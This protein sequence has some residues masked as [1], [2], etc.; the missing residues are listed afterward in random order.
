MAEATPGAPRTCLVYYACLLLT[1]LWCFDFWG[2][3]DPGGTAP[4]RVTQFLETAYNSAELIFKCKPTNPGLTSPPPPLLGSHI[5]GHYPL[6][7]ITPWPR[8]RQP[9]TASVPRVCW[10][11]SNQPILNLFTL[12]VPFLMQKPQQRLLSQFPLCLLTANVI[13]LILSVPH[14][15]LLRL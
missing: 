6:A 5:L 3:V 9:E 4:P 14:P 8:T 12:P 7:L 10:S 1:V 2:L 13:A 15:L 11:Y